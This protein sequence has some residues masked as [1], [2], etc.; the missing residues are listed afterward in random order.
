LATTYASDNYDNVKTNNDAHKATIDLIIK[1]KKGI[2]DAWELAKELRVLAYK[3][4][5][6]AEAAVAYRDGKII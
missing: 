3:E 6:A 4:L 5:K 2:T 1:S